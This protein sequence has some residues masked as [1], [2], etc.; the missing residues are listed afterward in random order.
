MAS[1]RTVQNLM[2]EMLKHTTPSA[3]FITI[4]RAGVGMDEISF[5]RLQDLQRKN[6][7]SQQNLDE[8]KAKLDAARTRQTRYNFATLDSHVLLPPFAAF[9]ILTGTAAG[10]LH[11]PRR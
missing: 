4:R 1:A 5:K 2:N 8:A 11:S 10:H 6:P 7:I 3:V 9:S